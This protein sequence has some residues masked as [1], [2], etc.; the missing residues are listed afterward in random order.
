MKVENS[1]Y[2][3][4]V[5]MC[6]YNGERYILEQINTI[7]H[8]TRIPDEIVICD[9]NSSDRTLDIISERIK[10]SSVSIKLIRNSAN[11]GYTKNFEKAISLCSGDIIVLSD[12][13]D[14]WDNNKLLLIEEQFLKSPDAGLVFTD[15][16]MVDDKLQT[17]GYSLWEVYKISPTIIDRINKGL[18]FEILMKKNIITG[19]TLAFRKEYLPLILPIPKE[20]VHDAWISLLISSCARIIPISSQTIKY[21]QHA[22]NQIG[23]PKEIL[24]QVKMAK[25]RGKKSIVEGYLQTSSLLDRLNTQFENGL[26]DRKYIDQ[27]MQ[28]LKHFKNRSEF[29]QNKLLRL[30]KIFSELVSGRYHK[31]SDGWKSLLKDLILY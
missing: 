26:L 13:D 27:I 20:H 12:Q 18:M 30:P 7:L 28:K 21:R 23:A 1:Q 2:T 16:D 10:K 24:S 8:Q 25:K 6:T 29:P 4:S 22:H 5:A 31:Y 19:A 17:K 3:V 9:D 11:L 15:A 14:Y